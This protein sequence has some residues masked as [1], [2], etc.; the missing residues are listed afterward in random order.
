MTR[1][2]AKLHIFLLLWYGY[3]WFDAFSQ[4]QVRLEALKAQIPMAEAKIRKIIRQQKDL[5]EY[6]QDV[7]K[8][9]AQIEKVAREV[10]K[11]QRQ[12]PE[13]IS[14]TE[15]LQEMLDIA[16][17]LNIRDV[18]VIP[19]EEENKGFYIV[20]EYSFSGTGTFLQ[21]LIFFEKIER[22]S[23][24]NRLLNIGEISLGVD[25]EK[26][27]GRFQLVDAR[28]SVQAYRYNPAHRESREVEA[29]QEKEQSAG[30]VISKKLQNLLE[31]AKDKEEADD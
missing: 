23:L 25:I 19:K 20:K 10:E 1:I 16:N 17:Q 28:F 2:L 27:K 12:L 5:E 22:I 24:E 4:H 18:H 8:K 31:S 3:Q 30:K 15:N 21:F 29:E 6:Y 13:S 9:K 26:Q 14:D 7:E 11:L